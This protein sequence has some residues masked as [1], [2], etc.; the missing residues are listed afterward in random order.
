MRYPFKIV[1][2]KL[3]NKFLALP[4]VKSTFLNI[5]KSKVKFLMTRRYSVQLKGG[6]KRI[7]SILHTYLFEQKVKNWCKTDL[8]YSA[9]P[10]ELTCVVSVALDGEPQVGHVGVTVRLPVIQAL[11]GG[12]VHA[13]TLWNS[14]VY[15][16]NSL[17]CQSATWNAFNRATS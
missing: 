15:Y 3:Q 8:P 16:I 1:R 14:T 17:L 4:H 7:F 6:N 10:T 5:F 2:N 12:Q 9:H 11:Q 13:V